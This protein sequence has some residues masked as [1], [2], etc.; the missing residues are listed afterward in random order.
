M[1]SRESASEMLVSNT[2]ETISRND[3]VHSAARRMWSLRSWK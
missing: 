1:L 3:S 2:D